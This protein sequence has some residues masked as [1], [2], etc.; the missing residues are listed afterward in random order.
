MDE[1]YVDLF[2]TD[3]NIISILKIYFYNIIL[4]MEYNCHIF[5]SSCFEGLHSQVPRLIKN[6]LEIGT[7]PLEFVHFIVGGCPDDKIYYQEGIEIVNVKYRCFEFTPLIY[8]VNNP[9]KY[10]FDYAFFTHDTVKFGNNFYDLINRELISIRQTTY[11]TMSIETRNPSMNI[12][13]YSKNIILKS[14]S[15]LLNLSIDT[16]NADILMNLKHKLVNYEDFIFKKNNYF[17]IDNTSICIPK[18][19]DGMH[20]TK[21][22]GYIRLF[23]RIDFIKYQS[24]ALHIQS[25]DICKINDDLYQN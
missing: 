5:I 12:G 6:I 23:N 25:I 3:T 4:Y 21:C 2:G 22:N 8:I 10:N 7:I 19:L 11:D 14:K 13:I 9:D 16:N 15:E 20:G 17:K 18:I 24:N 1:T